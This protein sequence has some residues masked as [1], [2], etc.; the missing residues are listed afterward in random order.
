[1]NEPPKPL[2][3]ITKYKA[4]HMLSDRYPS[5]TDPWMQDREGDKK[6]NCDFR[7]HI[8][9]SRSQHHA[10]SY[11]FHLNHLY[12]LPAPSH[13]KVEHLWWE[14]FMNGQPNCPQTHY[15]LT[16]V[17][18]ILFLF[19]VMKKT[20]YSVNHKKLAS[21]ECLTGLEVPNMDSMNLRK[22]IE[23]FLSFSTEI[24]FGGH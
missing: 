10:R 1:M 11:H 19:P 20:R 23:W 24:I 17:I 8:V 2:Y 9:G 6:R 16:Q 14:F 18:Q 4:T 7:L 13:A 5:S 22:V 21:P 3:A 12:L 15:S